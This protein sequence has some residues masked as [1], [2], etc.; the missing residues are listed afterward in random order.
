MPSYLARSAKLP[1]GLYILL[2]LIS[3]F[4]LFL[5]SSFLMISERQIISGS[6]RPIFA[7]FSPSESVLGADDQCAH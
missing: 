7:I 1:T 3:L 5:S 6:A 4:F 2:A